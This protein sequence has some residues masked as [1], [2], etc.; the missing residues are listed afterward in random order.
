VPGF[1]ELGCRIGFIPGETGK[2]IRELVE[3]TIREAAKLDPWLRDNP[4]E[5]E[6]LPFQAEPFYQDPDHPFVKAVISSAQAVAGEAVKVKPRGVTWTEDTRFARDFGFPA[7][8]MGPAG[9]RQWGDECDL[10]LMT[11][12][13]KVLAVPPSIGALWTNEKAWQEGMLKD[14]ANKMI[15]E[16]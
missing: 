15:I 10:D 9:E 14:K 13:V 6:W 4:P 5:V 8:S 11:R 2:S 16:C 7:L 3:G 1:A 12:L